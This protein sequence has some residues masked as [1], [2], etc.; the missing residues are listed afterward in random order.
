MGV[1]KSRART[2]QPRSSGWGGR[3]CTES[4]SCPCSCRLILLI[5]S[6]SCSRGKR[7]SSHLIL[8]PRA[9]QCG[10]VGP[11]RSTPCSKES[12]VSKRRR[13]NASLMMLAGAGPTRGAAVT[14]RWQPTP[15]PGDAPCAGAGPA[16]PPASS[17]PQAHPIEYQRSRSLEPHPAQVGLVQAGQASLAGQPKAASAVSSSTSTRDPRGMARC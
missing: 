1:F 8:P 7:F 15:A 2:L 17:V 11:A 14:A 5:S 12:R 6:S 9:T 10:R 13:T 16:E 3:T 4:S